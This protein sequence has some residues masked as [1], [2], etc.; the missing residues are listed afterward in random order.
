MCLSGIFILRLVKR[1]AVF[2]W[3]LRRCF[4]STLVCRKLILVEKSNTNEKWGE[5]LKLFRTHIMKHCLLEAHDWI[6]EGKTLLWQSWE[7]C[8]DIFFNDWWKYNCKFPQSNL[9]CQSC[10]W[11]K[12]KILIWTHD[13]KFEGKQILSQKTTSWSFS[14]RCCFVPF[15]CTYLV[16]PNFKNLVQVRKIVTVWFFLRKRVYKRS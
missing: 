7:K 3:R 13:T 11:L 6:P 4:L 12:G 1:G 10:L 8:S 5:V 16:R 9:E 2:S 15:G 14:K